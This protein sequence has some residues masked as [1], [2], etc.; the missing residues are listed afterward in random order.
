VGLLCLLLAA[1]L[2]APVFVAPQ[3][4]PGVHGGFWFLLKVFCYIYTF[5]WLRFTFPRYRFDQLMRLGWHFMI[6][7]AIVN[8]LGVGV[9]LVLERQYGWG[10]A[11]ALMVTTIG[12]LA[13]AAWLAWVGERTES[14]VV[15][16]A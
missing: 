2:A 11:P 15:G 10:L 5:M 1:A 8:V 12:T 6:P 4:K 7:V 16:G 13:V 9:A 3:L 14:P